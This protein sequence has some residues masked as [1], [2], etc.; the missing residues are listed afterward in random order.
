MPVCTTETRTYVGE[1]GTIASDGFAGFRI[2]QQY[3]LRY[4]QRPDGKIAVGLDQPHYT[5]AGQEWIMSPQEL[6]KWWVPVLT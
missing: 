6:A 2:N 1:P 4:R 3:Q 5:G